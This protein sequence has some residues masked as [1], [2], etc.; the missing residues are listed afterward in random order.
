MDI[1]SPCISICAVDETSGYCKGCYRTVDEV[2]SWLYYN[3]A[4]KSDVLDKLRQRRE[5]CPPAPGKSG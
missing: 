5:A 3:N 1:P 2:A 4:Q